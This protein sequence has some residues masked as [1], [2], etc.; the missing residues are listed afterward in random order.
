VLPKSLRTPLTVAPQAAER[1]SFLQRSLF[2]ASLLGFQHTKG[3]LEMPEI[4]TETTPTATALEWV[5]IP[6]E[7]VRLGGSALVAWARIAAAGQVDPY[8]PSRIISTVGL[9]DLDLSDTTARNAVHRLES[10]GLVIVDRAPGKPSTYSLDRGD[11]WAQLPTTLVDLDAGPMAAY[12]SLFLS[13]TFESAHRNTTVRRLASWLG[14]G[15]RTVR[16]WISELVA[17]GALARHGDYAYTLTPPPPP[18]QE[19]PPKFGRQKIKEQ[20]NTSRRAR[21]TVFRL[22]NTATEMARRSRKRSETTRPR[23]STTR[24]NARPGHTRSG[25]SPS[26]LNE[27]HAPLLNGRSSGIQRLHV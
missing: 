7:I 15:L 23:L 4:S 5:P 27:S 26:R 6:T 13:G 14:A 19:P 3:T 22:Q 25:K 12:C 21:K 20:S 16:R 2:V 17:T 24:T 10:T 9:A 1:T 11:R 8:D 18:P